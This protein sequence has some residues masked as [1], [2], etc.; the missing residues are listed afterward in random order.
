MVAPAMYEDDTNPSSNTQTPQLEA[1]RPGGG[2][3]STNTME[4]HLYAKGRWK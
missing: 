2:V 3:G 4:V 1:F